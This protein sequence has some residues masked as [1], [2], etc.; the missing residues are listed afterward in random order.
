MNDDTT[1][2]R[3]R[4]TLRD[5]DCVLGVDGYTA[6][7]SLAALER[8]RNVQ[9]AAEVAWLLEQSGARPHS[10]ASP[11]VALRRAVG[12]ALVRAGHRLAGSAHPG[13]SAAVGA[14]GAID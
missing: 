13:K 3:A 12:E 14:P 2:D 1:M 9:A 7:A 10:G 4:V 6:G 5:I 11:V 8:Q